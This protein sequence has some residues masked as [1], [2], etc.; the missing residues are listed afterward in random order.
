[1]GPGR[2]QR[3]RGHRATAA[4]PI[5]IEATVAD[6][7]ITDNATVGVNAA[8]QSGTN[9]AIRVTLSRNEITKHG[10]GV[11][12]ARGDAS[13]S[14]VVEIQLAGNWISRND[15]G[16][17]QNNGFT[18]NRSKGDNYIDLNRPGDVVGTLTN[19]GGK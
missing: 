17:E 19:V 8:L 14:G 10:T 4:A 11:F 1:M 16:V 9:G 18:L 2:A 7:Q 5:E 13:D 3:E 6:S 15:Y 12:G